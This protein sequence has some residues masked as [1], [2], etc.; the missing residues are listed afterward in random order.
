MTNLT[1]DDRKRAAALKA[2]DFIADG[3]IVG[4]GTGSTAAH[5]VKALGERVKAGLKITGVAT[6]T[7]AEALAIE[8]GITLVGIDEVPHIDITV[9]GADEADRSFR[10]IKGGGAAHLREKIVAAASR[11]MIAILD[12]S[13]LVDA[14]GRFPLPVEIV[15]FACKTTLRH[16][17][18]AAVAAG[19]GGNFIRLRGGEAHPVITDNG[20][21]IADLD[22]QSIPD[23]EALAA[24][25]SAIPG[26]VEHGLFLGLCSGLIIGTPSGVEVIEPA[27]HVPE[28]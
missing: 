14:L 18:D 27:P 3:Q 23:P 13:K 17:A 24:A 4:L 25:L 22:C 28:A 16:I 5:F 12:D 19:C 11:R 2:L 15:P 21:A 6:S 7:A 26:V 10:L 9:D 20:N 1:A 8:A